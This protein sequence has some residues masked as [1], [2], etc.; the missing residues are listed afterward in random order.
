LEAVYLDPRIQITISTIQTQISSKV[1]VNRLAQKANISASHLRH[2]FKMET[3]LT[4]MQYIKLIRMQKAEQLLLSTFLS[5]KEIMN[6]VGISNESYFSREFKRTFG[7]APLQYR[8]SI[9]R[10]GKKR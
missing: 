2:L 5:V 6:R 1:D 9:E 8:N 10:R 7:L 3:G 4:L